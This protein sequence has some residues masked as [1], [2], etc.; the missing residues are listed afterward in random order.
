MKKERKPINSNISL[1]DSSMISFDFEVHK[2]MLFVLFKTWNNKNV[3]IVFDDVIHF[4]YNPGDFISG[5]YQI[6]SD[7]SLINKCLIREY[8]NILSDHDYKLISIEDI[9]DFSVIEVVCRNLLISE[10]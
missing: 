10:S 6:V 3:K 4:L 7:P 5:I 2:Q 8:G 1:S 9:D